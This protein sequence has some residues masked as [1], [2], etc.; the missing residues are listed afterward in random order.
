MTI[1]DER[2]RVFG[3]VN[4]I[5]LAVAVFV[6]VL[7]PLAYA[8]YL[9]FRPAPVVITSVEPS[10]V[11]QGK[12]ERIRI[13]GAHFRP[14]MR[15]QIGNTQP[16]ELFIDTPGSAEAYV[17][18]VPPGTYD[19]I[20]YS[21]SEEVARLRNAVT[22]AAPEVAQGVTVQLAGAF[23]GLDAKRAAQLKPGRR[24]PDAGSPSYEIISLDAPRPDVRRIRAG[25]VFVSTS[26][27]GAVQ[28]PAIVRARCKLVEQTPKCD[29]GGT[30]LAPGTLIVIPGWGDFAIAEMRGDVPPLQVDV[31]VR[32]LGRADLVALV[33]RGDVGVYAG[34]A[35]R[36]PVVTS[37]GAVDTVAAQV[38]SRS[39]DATSGEEV[40]RQER[41][42]AVTATIRIKAESTPGGIEYRSSP[43]KLGAPFVFETSKYL[44]RGT[45][46]RAVAAQ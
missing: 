3:R 28:V 5:D 36:A 11:A 41:V 34:P 12:G 35:E 1:I 19:L 6:V 39:G 40:Q 9:L 32:F 17:P 10:T 13:L 24:F 15:A 21:E 44:V 43:L 22:V 29:V 18:D 30:Q 27:A 46:V 45:V 7:V 38:T 2:G 8:A 42:G 14:F 26:V 23:T 31:D 25:D 20:F 33:H 16:K 37:V 4:L